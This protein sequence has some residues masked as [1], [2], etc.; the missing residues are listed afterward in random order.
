MK[1]FLAVFD[2]YKMSKSTMEYAIQLTQ[3]ANA[4]LVEVFLDDFIYRTYN[5]YKVMTTS[6]N[7]DAVMK[8]LDAKDKNYETNTGT[9][10]FFRLR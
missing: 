1:K 6:K 3:A 4:H 9:Y 8:E 7:Y 5:V 2:G 10:R